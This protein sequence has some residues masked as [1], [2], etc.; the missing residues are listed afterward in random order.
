[1][2]TVQTGAHREHGQGCA[3]RASG[4]RIARSQ[5]SEAPRAGYGRGAAWTVPPGI[6]TAELDRDSGKLAEAGTPPDKRYMEYFLS[7]T[8]P[9][10]LRV[11]ARRLF[12]W[13]PLP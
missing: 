7:G 5:P 2:G 3:R 8:E 9:G 10:A 6:V 4:D 1:M 12:G 11:D 13:G